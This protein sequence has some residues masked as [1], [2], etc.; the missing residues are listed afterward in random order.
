MFSALLAKA[1][2]LAPVTA[3]RLR[4]PRDQESFSHVFKTEH[5]VRFFASERFRDPSPRA[6]I[7]SAAAVS[8]NLHKKIPVGQAFSADPS[9]IGRIQNSV[10]VVE[11]RTDFSLAT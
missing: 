5:N 10:E 1:R 6:P 3:G 7:R 4:R 2:L 9:K 11:S 8:H